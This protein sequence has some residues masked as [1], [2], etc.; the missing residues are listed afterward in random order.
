MN[1]HIFLSYSRHNTALMQRL[2]QDLRTAD[3]TVW[4][5][6]GIEPGSASWKIDIEKA[7]QSAACVVVIFSP[8]ARTS[9]WVRAELDYAESQSKPIFA[10]LAEGEESTAVPFGYSTHQWIDLR[11]PDAYPANF[12]RLKNAISQTLNEKAPVAPI[13]RT[14]LMPAADV[15]AKTATAPKKSYIPTYGLAGGLLFIALSLLVF[16]LTQPPAEPEIA[17]TGTPANTLTPTLPPLDVQPQFIF[18]HLTTPDTW[19][20][21]DAGDFSLYAPSNWA[22]I[23]VNSEVFNAFARTII[24]DFDPAKGIE[25]LPNSQIVLYLGDLVGLQ[26]LFAVKE[27]LNLDLS[28]AVLSLRYEDFVQ[29][30]GYTIQDRHAIQ[31]PNGDI[32]IRLIVKPGEH[33][34]LG[35]GHVYV[36]MRGQEAF[37]FVFAAA[38]AKDQDA[39]QN[40]TQQII[41][42]LNLTPT[43]YFETDD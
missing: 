12:E 6:E 28:L 2:A 41:S 1:Y 31:H 30:I 34:P 11:D 3:F 8:S 40:V 33:M 19:Q 9:R 20:F 39:F 37:M 10:L 18:P 4:I 13:T 42:T 15:P 25:Q 27:T 17:A 16:V 26:G 29:Q 38:S 24:A 36:F 5:D 22:R 7:I 14:Q 43:G 21:H 23:E 35:I 32:A